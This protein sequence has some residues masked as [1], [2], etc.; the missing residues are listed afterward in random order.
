MFMKR[1]ARVRQFDFGLQLWLAA[2]KRFFT[3]A[4]PLC[5]VRGAK[6]A[7]EEMVQSKLKGISS[8]RTRL[9]KKKKNYVFLRICWTG[10]QSKLD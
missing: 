5:F 1:L 8:V 2:L 9:F 7:N 4:L 10:I 3:P 6:L